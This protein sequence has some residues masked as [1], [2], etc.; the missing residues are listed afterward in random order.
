[1]VPHTRLST[2][3][4]GSARETENRIRNILQGQRRRPPAPLI[5]TTALA[6]LLCG[7][8]VSC[9]PGDA[10]PETTPP[11]A[12]P[13]SVSRLPD[14][15][16]GAVQPLSAAFPED[17]A[18]E[19]L[20]FRRAVS[21]T[22]VDRS[23]IGIGERLLLSHTAGGL[24]LGVLQWDGGCH[25]AG[26]GNLA[27]GVMDNASGE[28]TGEPVILRGDTPVLS[29]WMADG[30]L[31]VLCTATHTGMGWDN[32]TGIGWFAFDEAGL[33]QLAVPPEGALA[34]LPDGD[35]AV[36][37]EALLDI[38]R[39][40][41]WEHRMAVA[42]NAG[43]ALYRRSQEWIDNYYSE[44][45][46]WLYE[47]YLP[48]AG[49]GP[50]GV[51]Y[52]YQVTVEGSSAPLV[53]YTD[54]TES[55]VGPLAPEDL[56]TRLADL[57][58]LRREDS[59]QN[60]VWLLAED[61]ASDTAL[62]G[63]ALLPD[64]APD[65]AP[66]W[67]LEEFYGVILRHG[68]RLYYRDLA[69]YGNAVDGAAPDLWLGD[70]DGDGG[71]EAAVVLC[72]QSGAGLQLQDLYL[73]ELED[74]GQTVSV[75]DYDRFFSLLQVDYDEA[76]RTVTLAGHDPDWPVPG[77]AVRLPEDASQG[78]FLGLRAG[79]F[80]SFTLEDGQIKVHFPLQYIAQPAAVSYF[81]T[82]TADVVN[83]ADPTLDSFREYVLVNP[84]LR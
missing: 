81:A 78:G 55:A 27:V 56:P 17:R 18:L 75:Y 29:A 57:S 48:F 10:P 19:E 54:A 70:F 64:S 58:S 61:K 24:T 33:E 8:L 35:R 46:Q 83:I 65:G 38:E 26:N 43:L 25:A 39:L 20:L 66:G 62:Y 68:D 77:W 69:W 60:A 53:V 74:P 3:L 37:R 11:E 14:L 32:M 42:G 12:T 1:M 15:P 50:G 41:F 4:T 79:S 28:L 9:Q 21:A 51:P 22:E 63:A 30:R 76:S 40:D 72:S 59:Y 73:F 36:F 7:S 16:D 52:D 47:A 82:L 34:E 13:P 80:R 23:E 5:L 45:D 71:Q 31:Y 2:R 84:T 49:D 67:E 44:S 6:I